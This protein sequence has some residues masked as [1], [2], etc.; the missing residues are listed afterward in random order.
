MLV[1][2]GG[3]STAAIDLKELVDEVRERGI[4]L[5]LLIRFSEILKAAGRRAQRGLPP[6]HRRVRLQGRLP[7]RLPDQGQPAPLRGRGDRRVRPAL[8]LRPGGRL[9]AR[10][11]GGDGA[12]RR[13][14]GADHLQRLQGRGVRRDRAPRLQARPQRHPGG[15]EALRAAADR[16]DRAAHWAS[17]PRIGIRARLATRG[18]GRWEASGGDRSKFGLSGRELLEAIALPARERP[19]RLASSCCTSTSAARSPRSARSRTR[20]ARRP[21]STSSWSSWARP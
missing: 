10:A 17:G 6:R 13:R 8:P 18:A 11:A 2:P 4:G 1:H 3:P 14:G 7:R 5:P 19:A 20:C 21:G 15:R 16:R 9:Q 12:A